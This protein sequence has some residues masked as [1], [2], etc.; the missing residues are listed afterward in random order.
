MNELKRTVFYQEHRKANAKI[1]PFAGYE[2]PVQYP[3]GIIAEHKA[4]RS[5]A[6]MFDVSHMGEFI[7]LG[8]DAEN[9]VNT[10]ITNDVSR[11]EP[12]AVL[13][14]AMCYPEGTIVDDLLV[15][16][17]NPELFMLVVNAS[18]IE[19]DFN[20]IVSNRGQFNVT[21]ENH[22]DNY[23][24]IALQGPES[25]KI[26]C[27]LTPVDSA[28]IG[29]YHFTIGNV[30]QSEVIISRTGYTGEDGFELYCKD[31]KAALTIWQELLRVGQPL[32]LKLCGL[33]ARDTLRLE[34][35]FALYGNDIDQTTTPMEAGLGWIVKLKKEVP[36]IG[37]SVLIDQKNQ[38]FK[39]KLIAFS[40]PER[41]IPRH[42]YPIVNALGQEIGHVTSGCFSPILEKSIGMGYVSIP[43]ADNLQTFGIKIRD[44]VI[45][46]AKVK[47]PF[48]KKPGQS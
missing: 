13:Y 30:C 19:K 16:K 27:Q 14:S 41:L 9:F 40:Y 10:I 29:Y 32:G 43:D 23:S 6:G 48:Y 2:M 3:E 31:P 12:M 42:N 22:S 44:K 47:T 36:F 45:E 38:G 35:G 34:M 11:I 15:Y 8:P 28:L 21:I 33:G 1:V 18:N 25:V 5:A 46:A 24:L 39:T 17:H 4:V 37:Q 26:L 20:H 7:V